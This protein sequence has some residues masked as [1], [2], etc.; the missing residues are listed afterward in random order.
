MGVSVEMAVFRSPPA[1]GWFMEEAEKTC[2]GKG[3]FGKGMSPES[4]SKREWKSWNGNFLKGNSLL[5][6]KSTYCYPEKD[7]K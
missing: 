5:T 2:M 4:N 1:S 6:W 3:L 7:R